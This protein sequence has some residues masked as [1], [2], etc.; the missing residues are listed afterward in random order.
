MIWALQSDPHVESLYW[1]MQKM[2][3][4]RVT[5]TLNTS[6]QNSMPNSE[7]GGTGAHVP[8]CAT[9]KPRGRTKVSRDRCCSLPEFRP[10]AACTTSTSHLETKQIPLLSPERENNGVWVAG[11]CR[12]WS[13]RRTT[14]MSPEPS[15]KHRLSA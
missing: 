3:W 12:G 13:G 15:G 4:P 8:P 11:D 1:C 14:R 2:H 5:C 9:S 7:M 10:T 6:T